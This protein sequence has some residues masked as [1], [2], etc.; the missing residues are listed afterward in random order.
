MPLVKTLIF[1]IFVPGFLLIVVP[2]WLVASNL[3]R[4]FEIGILRYL[5]FIPIGLGAIAQLW[6]MWN[7]ATFGKGTP[8]P[9]DPPKIFVSKGLYRMMRNPMY[10]G[11][12]LIL[13]GEALV[14]QS[15]TLFAY[16]FLVWLPQHLFVIFYE[17]PAL[18]KKFGAEYEAYLKTVPRWIPKL[19]N[20]RS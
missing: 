11:A 7:F 4:S 1:A 3:N 6:S 18:K 15:W 14:Y 19:R 17:E 20:L 16:A 2:C 12:A 13:I 9:I 5:G 8:A 10:V